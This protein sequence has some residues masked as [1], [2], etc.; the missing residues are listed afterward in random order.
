[1]LV[2]EHRDGP[3]NPLRDAW[4]VDALWQ[5]ENVLLNLR[6]EAQEHEDLGHAGA[7][8]AFAAGDVGLT[9][10]LSGVELALSFEALRRACVDE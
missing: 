5:V 7:G 3:H 1:M 10:D 4:R 6:G 9:G 2:V 8:D